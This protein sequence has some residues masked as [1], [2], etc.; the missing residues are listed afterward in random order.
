MYVHVETCPHLHR[1][2]ETI[3]KLGCTAGVVLN[4]GT[5][6]VAVEAV[7]HMVDMVLVMSVDPGFSGAQYQPEA[8]E[9]ISRIRKMLDEVNPHAMIAVDGGIT[10]ETLPQVKQ[11]GAQFF[12]A[13]TAIF[14]NSNGIAAGVQSLRSAIAEH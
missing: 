1:T 4:P 14:K 7:L 11:A 10:H 3:R 13:A 6:V 5:P 9:R 12:I 2:L 8:P